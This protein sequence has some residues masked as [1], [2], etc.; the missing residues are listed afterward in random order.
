MRAVI[1]NSRGKTIV[2]RFVHI[3]SSDF[4]KSGKRDR[5]FEKVHGRVSSFSP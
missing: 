5:T 4:K 1:N 3:Y 2:Y